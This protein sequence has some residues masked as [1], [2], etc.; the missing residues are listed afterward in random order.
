V[1]WLDEIE[2]GLAGVQSSGLADAGVTARV[3][4]TLN[5]WMQEK[6]KAVFVVATANDISQLPPELLRKGRFDEIFFVDLPAECERREVFGIHL[7]KRKR[8][9][10]SFDLDALAAAAK[11]FS[12]AEI[13]QAIISGLLVAFEQNRDVTTQDILDAIKQ[14]V[15]LSVTMREDIDMVRHWAKGRARPASR[16]GLADVELEGARGA[17]LDGSTDWVKPGVWGH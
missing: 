14:T 17:G 10:A 15:P 1:L 9:A 11:G 6:T 2:K 5:T 13:E 16:F 3:F 7:G 4:A 12:G 8:D